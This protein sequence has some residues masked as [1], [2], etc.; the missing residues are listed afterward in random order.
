[1]A[2]GIE[3]FDIGVFY[4][5]NPLWHRNPAYRVINRPVNIDEVREVFNW[6]IEKKQLSYV[7]DKN[8]TV[9]VNAFSLIRKD[10]QHILVDSVGA[11]FEAAS[12]LQMV[13]IIENGVLKAFPDLILEGAATLWNNKTAFIQLKAKEF[14][15]KG[16]KSP[17]FTRMSYVNPLGNGAY[18]ALVHNE[19][20]VCANTLRVAESEG[21]ANRSLKKFS[22]LNGAF[23]KLNAYMEELT[24]QWLM[25]EKH[26]AVLENMAKS[27]VDTA[28]VN[29]F[30][31]FV[32]PQTANMSDVAI[33]H[34][35]ARRQAVIAQFNKDQDLTPDAA[36]SKYGLL[37]AL[38]YVIDHETFR[39]DPVKTY[40]DNIAGDRMDLK[41][42]AFDWLANAA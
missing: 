18:K 32:Y 30:T 41:A 34:V 9:P 35:N 37:Q 22:H 25:L 14:Q 10:T 3:G 33:N 6:E 42:D 1:M 17:M 4:S 20:V 23:I 8:E 5:N 2:A 39:K 27:Q 13:D 7:N 29:N 11:K 16:D 21:K 40:W 28:L 36:F 26:N 24:E 31:K 15:I 12:N 19:R 38:T